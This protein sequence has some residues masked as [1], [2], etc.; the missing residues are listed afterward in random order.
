[1]G[2]SASLP[3]DKKVLIV[4]G[5]Y[6]GALLAVELIKNGADVLL[7]DPKSYF[8]HNVATVRAVVDKGT[9]SN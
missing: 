8:Y 4:G 5:G 6:A 9:S 7:I 3:K 1:M 2:G